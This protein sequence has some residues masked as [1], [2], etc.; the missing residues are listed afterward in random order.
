MS[1]AVTGLEKEVGTLLIGNRAIAYAGL[2]CTLLTPF[3]VFWLPAM[4]ALSH[5]RA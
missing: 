2:T 3:A 1:L 5:A 4:R